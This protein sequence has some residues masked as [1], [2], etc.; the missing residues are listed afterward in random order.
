[1]IIVADGG[2]TSTDWRAIENEGAVLSFKGRGVNPVF[3]DTETLFS[4]FSNAAEFLCRRKSGGGQMRLPAKIYFYGAGIVSEEIKNNVKEALF[5]AFACENIVVESDLL[6]AAR[7]LFGHS[8]GIMAILGTGSNSGLYDGEKITRSIGAGGFILGD[9]GSGAALGKTL[10][11]DYIKEMIPK[12][13]RNELQ[14]RYSLNYP[15]IMEKVYHNRMPSEYIASFSF[16]IEEFVNH[17][18]IGKLL[19]DNFKSFFERNILVYGR[20]D[21]KTGFVGSVAKIYEKFVRK[22]ASDF[23]YDVALILQ[24]AADGLAKYHLSELKNT[25]DD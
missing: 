23:G 25:N 21:L 24:S 15:I 16:F 17:P 4:V 19:S 5:R 2:S 6:A 3:Q 1:M 14:Q 12:E 22:T 20:K 7:A 9:E 10:L 13:L 11:S 8:E 18:Y